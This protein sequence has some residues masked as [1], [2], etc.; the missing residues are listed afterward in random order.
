MRGVGD[1]TAAQ[2]VRLLYRHVLVVAAVHHSVRIAA[3]TTSREHTTRET[4]GVVIH[5]VQT[6]ALDSKTQINQ[7]SSTDMSTGDTP[8]LL[9]HLWV[10]SG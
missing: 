9:K 10:A 2:L 7:Y 1:A 8:M 3:T 4:C 6:R 5:V